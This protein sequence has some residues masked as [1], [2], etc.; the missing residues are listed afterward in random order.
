[1]RFP[2]VA[3]HFYPSQKRRLKRVIKKSFQHEL[4]P[5]P[6]SEIER[7]IGRGKV[8]GGVFPHAGYNYSG[9]IVAHSVKAFIE[10]GLPDTLVIIGP[11]HTGRG[12][13]LAMADEDF[14]TPIGK[15]DF[16]EEIGEIFSDIGIPTDN[17]SHRY[18][19]SLEVQLPYFQYFEEDFSMVAINMY[20]QNYE[21]A[22]LLAKG[23]KEAF[24]NYSKK[25]GIVAST[26][27][28]H[29]GF[30][31]G[32]QVPPG[33]TA[34]EFAK[35][36]DQKAIGAILEMDGVGLLD[37]VESEGI[38]MC[39]PGAVAAMLMGLKDRA[40]D[41]KLL[42]YATSYDILP[43]SSAVGYGSMVVVK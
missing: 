28:T 12:R 23:I 33:M 4:G 36:K 34:G 18:E 22:N 41:V 38:S 25:V 5:G 15:V 1:M 21:K 8:L 37:T 2:A 11:N 16:D 7:G 3:G 35:E 24:R 27:F 40:S 39:G 13:D 26:D 42:K 43:D 32:T 14:K 10:S 17:T 29:C 19:H 6:V 30:N 20:R 9:P 31:Y